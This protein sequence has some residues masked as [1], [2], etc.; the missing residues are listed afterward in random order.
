LR[1]LDFRLPVA[2]RSIDRLLMIFLLGGHAKLKR[3]KRRLPHENSQFSDNRWPAT[4][5][6][7]RAECPRSPKLTRGSVRRR[8]YRTVEAEREHVARQ[9]RHIAGLTPD[10]RS[11]LAK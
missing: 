4:C 11:L 3:K 6:P 5:R 7:Q 9:S 2:P 8:S 1:G 10:N